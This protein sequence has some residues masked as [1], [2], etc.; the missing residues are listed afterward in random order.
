[1]LVC[2]L[3]SRLL[4]YIGGDKSGGAEQAVGMARRSI[5]EV[6]RLWPALHRWTYYYGLGRLF[7]NGAYATGTVSYTKSTNQITADAGTGVSF[8]SWAASG[9][10]RIGD[11]IAKVATRNS[12]TVLTLDA[13]L[14]YQADIAA[15]TGYSLYQDT[16]L[17]WSDF[18]A[19]DHFIAE[20][21]FGNLGYVQPGEWEWATRTAEREGPPAYYTFFPSNSLP[22]RY[23]ARIWPFPDVNQTLECVYSRRLKPI[24]YVSET[25]GRVTVANADTTVTGVG[26]KFSSSMVGSY[27]RLS[28][29]ATPPSGLEGPNPTVLEAAITAVASATSLTI[30]T[31]APQ[32]VNGA[33]YVVSDVL[34]I[35]VNTMALAFAWQCQLELARSMSRKDAPAVEQSAMKYLL[36]AKDADARNFSRQVAG[37]P[38]SH[39][40]Q[41][42]YMPLGPDE[43]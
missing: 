31:A 21:R 23:D 32:A 27:I 41:R 11:I 30:G 24:N 13:Q 16:Y 10:I 36:I 17:L 20:Y 12:A 22:E 6:A 9:N 25:R 4:D 14:T 1:M 18:M 2:D 7:L 15:L 37:Q 38:I 39:R 34:D 28:A 35:E 26:T 33:S 5:F 42:K 3:E 40:R 19:T 43:G 29:D 8:P